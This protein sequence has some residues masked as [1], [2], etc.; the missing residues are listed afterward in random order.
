MLKK[1]KEYLETG[2]P[3]SNSEFQKLF[4]DETYQRYGV[5]VRT[6]TNATVLN[7]D[8]VPGFEEGKA[9]EIHHYVFGSVSMMHST[10]KM[11]WKDL[12]LI[13]ILYS[14][15]F[16][17]WRNAHPFWTYGLRPEINPMIQ[18]II[19]ILHAVK[20]RNGCNY[21]GEINAK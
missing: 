5:D 14:T 2:Y 10:A 20:K 18:E 16:K 9:F 11:A 3:K 19:N 15:N 17:P 12:D 7:L 1:V 8:L 6:L 13:I 4:S 21:K